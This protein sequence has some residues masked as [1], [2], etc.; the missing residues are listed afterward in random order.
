M[1][2]TTFLTTA[3][4][5]RAVLLTL[6]TGGFV[7][8]HLA[9]RPH[10]SVAA[11]HLQTVLLLCLLVVAV[12]GASTASASEMA[13]STSGGFPSQS[14][15]A[16]LHVVFGS[17]VPAMALVGSLVLPTVAWASPCRRRK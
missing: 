15:G 3:P 14:L 1:L 10:R 8:L 6:L 2:V 13:V 17:V 7:V 5:V 16:G 9:A 11:R 12:G 4:G